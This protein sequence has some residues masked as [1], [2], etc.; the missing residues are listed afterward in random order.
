MSRSSAAS[1][2][3]VIPVYA[4]SAGL[5]ELVERIVATLAGQRRPFEIVL[6]DDCSPDD[7]WSKLEALRERYGSM[8]KIASLARNHGQHN[9]LL[10]GFSL[11][12]GGVVVTMDDD[13]QHPPEAIPD[14]V[15]AIDAGFDLAIAEYDQK[16]HSRGRNHGGALIDRLIRR[17][18]Q[19]PAEFALT[20]FRAV[21]GDV[22]R[23]ASAMSGGYPYVTCMLLTHSARPTNVA[24]H[25][26][27]RKHGTSNYSPRRS[28]ALAMNLLF[29]YSGAPVHAV[30]ILSAVS[31]VG[32]LTIAGTMLAIGLGGDTVPGWAST[33]LAI[34]AGNA[35]T[36][37]CLT[38][39][40]IYVG[41]IS[42]ML[43]G[44]RQSF[45]IRAMRD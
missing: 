33:V 12:T 15:A 32:T 36:L 39:L 8:L 20:S 21:D 44:T 22:V 27:Q 7:S 31:L 19:L 25:H 40:A 30:A 24:V 23:R 17:M 13:L 5:E 43:S 6:V 4:S 16:R 26:D 2:S 28:L 9:A 45:T 38:V 41:R 35:I 37:T 3:V 29:S 14:L 42:H 10:C 1:I 18:F 34:F 11:A